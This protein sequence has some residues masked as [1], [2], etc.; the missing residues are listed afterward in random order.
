MQMNKDTDICDY[1]LLDWAETLPDR[2]I[3]ELILVIESSS[4]T[5]PASRH[6]VDRLQERL[7][8]R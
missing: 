3:Q 6:I 5:T 8:A 2:V 7:E 4:V 1:A